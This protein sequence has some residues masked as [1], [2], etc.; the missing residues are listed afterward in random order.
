MNLI[1]KEDYLTGCFH[2]FVDDT[3]KSLLKLT[4]I[5]R[6][7]NERTHIEGVDKFL[8]QVL[9]HVT[10]HD[11]MSQ[12]LRYRRLTDA[13]FTNKNRVI[14]CPSAQYLQYPT[15]LVVTSYDGV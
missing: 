12:A 6:T 5:F 10:A 7:G 11:T 9:R 14:F 2:Y 15:D 13:G 1:Y 8:L 3:F 4:L